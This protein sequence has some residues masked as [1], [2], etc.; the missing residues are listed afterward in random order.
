MDIIHVEKSG[1]IKTTLNKGRL[2]S[3]Q[4]PNNTA[5]V[6]IS[7]QPFFAG[8]LQIKLNQVAVFHEGNPDFIGSRI[9]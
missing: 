8:L 2:H 6:N 5:P 1:A 4:N 3:R 9:Y 7:D